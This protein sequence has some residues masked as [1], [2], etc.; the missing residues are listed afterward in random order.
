MAFGEWEMNEDLE[1]AIDRVDSFIV[2]VREDL[3]EIDGI[4]LLEFL[5]QVTRLRVRLDRLTDAVEARAP[6]GELEGQTAQG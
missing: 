1:A 2:S 5:S 4:T 3:V 6:L